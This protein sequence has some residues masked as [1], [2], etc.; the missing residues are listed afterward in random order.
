MSR[1]LSLDSFLLLFS[2]PECSPSSSVV[3]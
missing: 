1:Q 2:V 3:F